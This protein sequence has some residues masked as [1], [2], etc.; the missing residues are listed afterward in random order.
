[1]SENTWTMRTVIYYYT[2]TGNSLWTARALAEKLGDTELVP[3]HQMNNCLHNGSANSV[4]LVFPVHMWGVPHL[5]RDFLRVMKKQPE[6]YHFAVAVNAGQVSRTLLQLEELMAK[7]GLT[8]SAGFDIE[9]PSNYIPWG[10]PGPLE[11]RLKL[12]DSAKGQIEVASTYISDRKSG[13]I[14]KGPLWQRLI[15]TLIYK[16]TYNR[17]RTMDK[18]FN[19]DGTCTSCRICERVCPAENVLLQAGK[20]AWHGSCEQCLA[21]IQ[22]CPARCIQYGVKTKDYERYHHPEVR[23]GDVMRKQVGTHHEKNVTA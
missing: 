19:I 21:C 3:M 22:W 18:S 23:L 9:L 17:M 11:K 20:P 7:D 10:G 4:G 8:L 13:L 12:F 6:A 2:G 5:V 14:E 1:M 16:I 15:F